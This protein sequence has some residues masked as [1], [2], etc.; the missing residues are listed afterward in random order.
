MRIAQISPPFQAVPPKASGGTQRI[1]ACLA[2]HLVRRGH[3]VVVYATGD[4][5]TD[6]QLRYI[7]ER[8]VKDGSAL[9][10]LMHA[11]RAFA[12]ADK[13]D[14]IHNHLIPGIPF[15]D[16]CS[17]PCIT[18]VDISLS[19]QNL[20]HFL[21]NFH[22]HNY[23]ALNQRQTQLLPTLNWIGIVPDGINTE[24]WPFSAQKQDYVV[25]IGRLRP[26]KGPHLAIQAALRSGI[27][28]VL[29]GPQEPE[30]EGFFQR[31]IVPYLD[32]EKVIYLGEM[33]EERK[34]VLR[35]ARALLFPTIW[36]EAFGLVML[37]AM[38]CGTPVIAFGLGAVP[39]VVKH[40]ETGLIVSGVDEMV[41]GISCISD[42]DPF[43]CRDYIQASFSVEAMVEGFLK[44]YSRV[45]NTS[46][47]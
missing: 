27:R 38:A 12:E 28:L 13:F 9:Y 19:D 20:R 21:Q 17:T 2:D 26:E 30:Q 11:A 43:D 6:A 37:E 40:R 35:H 7:F 45:A 41:E 46:L 31:E 47:F 44:I 5:H 8:P 36:E 42:I 23:V 16:F 25:W 39:E 22:Y 3:D 24:E 4:S 32:S 33:A 29:I 1:V 15:A 18:S 10:T 14:I 34:E